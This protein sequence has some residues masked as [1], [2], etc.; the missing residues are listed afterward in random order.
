[1]SVLLLPFPANKGCS[2]S[3]WE[4]RCP[5]SVG[6]SERKRSKSKDWPPSTKTYPATVGMMRKQTLT[7]ICGPVIAISRSLV[8]DIIGIYII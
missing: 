3:A 6:I 1:M 4:R 2:S 5:V 7:V 8:W